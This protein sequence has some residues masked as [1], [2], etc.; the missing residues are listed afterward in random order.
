MNERT[1]AQGTCTNGH[2]RPDDAHLYTSSRPKPA[3][4]LST[5]STSTRSAS[6][7]P[8]PPKHG[9]H[10]HAR[11]D[12][13]LPPEGHSPRYDAHAAG[14]HVHLDNGQTAKTESGTW[15]FLCKY[16]GKE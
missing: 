8:C 10:G 9:S 5:R 4:P 12:T 7:R 16:L 1:M 15:P 13:G 3:W 6:R 11:R 2:A 14:V